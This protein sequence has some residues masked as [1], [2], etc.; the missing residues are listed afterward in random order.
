MISLQCPAFPAIY[1]DIRTY[2]A[3]GKLMPRTAGSLRMQDTSVAQLHN[4]NAKSPLPPSQ[5][6]PQRMFPWGAARVLCLRKLGGAHELTQQSSN[7]KYFRHFNFYYNLNRISTALGI[8][9]NL[10]PKLHFCFNESINFPSVYR[11][12]LP[13]PRQSSLLLLQRVGRDFWAS[14]SFRKACLCGK[15]R[16]LYLTLRSWVNK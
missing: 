6:G 4:A 7:L 11:T 16:T 8:E 2:N 14:S 3:A 1:L 12:S 5:G 10:L 15:G 9:E 13:A